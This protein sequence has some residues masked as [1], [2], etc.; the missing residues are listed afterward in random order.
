MGTIRRDEGRRSPINIDVR[1]PEISL[2]IIERTPRI[3][4]HH[5]GRTLG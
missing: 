2:A 5:V 4:T 3:T 1:N